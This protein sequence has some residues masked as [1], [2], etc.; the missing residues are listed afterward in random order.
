MI[1]DA[2]AEIAVAPDLVQRPVMLGKQATTR[3][4]VGARSSPGSISS[5]RA[6]IRRESAHDD[7][8][9]T[10]S[11]ASPRRQGPSCRPVRFG[12]LGCSSGR[13]KLQSQSFQMSSPGRS[14]KPPNGGFSK[15]REQ[16]VPRS[17]RQSVPVKGL[18]GE[19]NFHNSRRVSDLLLARSGLILMCSK[20]SQF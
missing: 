12:S 10:G 4:V 17:L 9:G 8:Q 6:Y 13:L 7:V 16:R 5:W 20:V 2:Q 18:T 1:D 14:E 19:L 11:P 15:R 3:N